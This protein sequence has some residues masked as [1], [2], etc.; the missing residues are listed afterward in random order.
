[1]R[2]Q[3]GAE[4]YEVGV[5]RGVVDGVTYFLLDHHDLFDGL[6][7]GYRSNERIRRR[8]ALGR[9]AAEVMVRFRL[10][11]QVV[12][13]NDAAASLVSGV[14]RG[15]P[16]YA[17][18]PTFAHTSFVHIVH[19]GGWQYFDCYDRYEDGADLFELFNVPAS[20]ASR[21]TDPRDDGLF[22][23]MAA[24]IRFAD[25]V[26]TV[27]PSYARQIE[28]HCD[29]LE[30][31]LHDV[32]G[33]N[34]GI[35]KDFRRGVAQ[36]LARSGLE[37]RHL[38]RLRE[39]IA[40]DPS[41]R[42]K[43]ERSF[44]EL[45]T[46]HGASRPFRSQA[47]REE[48]IRMRT[49]LLVQ[50]EY[51]LTVDPDQVLYVMIH[52][53]S[54]QKG[55]RILLDASQGIFRDL[56][57]QAILGGPVAPNDHRAEQLAAGMRALMEYYPRFGRHPHRLSGDQPAA[58]RCRRVPDAVGVRAGRHLPTGGD[59]LRLSGGGARH[60]RSARHGGAATTERRDGARLRGAV[61]RLSP[62]CL[63]RRH[64]ALH[65]VLPPRDR[66]SDPARPHQRPARH[67]VVGPRRAALSGGTARPPGD[68]PGRGARTLT[69]NGVPGTNTHRSGHPSERTRHSTMSQ[70]LTFTVEPNLPP[71]LAPLA[72][73]A[74]DFW[75]SWHF[76]AI[77]LFMRFGNDLWVKTNQTPVR[78]LAEASQE[79][80]DE[81]ER[82]ESVPGAPGP[83]VR[84]LPRLSPRRAVVPRST[85]CRGRLFL[86]GVR[87][88]RH[89]A[90]LLG[91]DWACCP[92]TT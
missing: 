45:L 1:M 23:L 67:R 24:G 31:L 29:G 44:P 36:R 70:R 11:P 4:H 40:A 47:R 54:D 46:D 30:P 89:A 92:A 42:A 58:A 25:R 6:Y 64:G 77:R 75:I 35:G 18:G 28:Q 83:G 37:R 33:I 85:R 62:R 48:V 43:V 8:L 80:L 71:R 38:P 87:P 61:R 53:V 55:F 68:G 82:D 22:N 66:Q 90:D 32:I 10:A 88:G 27:S 91:R 41:L 76:D 34:N 13:T 50:I 57:V 78:L 12:A 74:R 81:L 51:G 21:F 2:F 15:D 65:L 73:L 69:E 14:V 63:S 5:H 17:A 79:R 7:W 86:D 9:A 59:E 20:L 49:K 84:R 72:A 16:Y 39:R 52:R 56:G 19:N 26:F 3:L 60:R